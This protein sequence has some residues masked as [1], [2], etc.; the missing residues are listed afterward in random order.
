MSSTITRLRS[1]DQIQIRTGAVQGIG[2]QGPSGP[3]GG[4]GPEGPAGPQG[5]KGDTGF[6]SESAVL[7]TSG[8]SPQS[9]AASTNTLVNFPTVV[10]DEMSAKQSDTNF[11]P[12]AG[13]YFVTAYVNFSKGTAVTGARIIRILQNGAV[14]WANTL[15]NTATSTLTASELSVAG[16]LVLAANDIITVQVWHNDSVSLS[17]NPARLFI[18]RTG[19]GPQGPEGPQG[20]QGPVGA[21]GAA[22]AQGPAGTVGNNN[23]TFAQIAAGTG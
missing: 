16:G 20:P 12:G 5:A 10:V 15:P 2:P 18:S 1:G 19:P 8:G 6:V 11:R 3:T 23:T 7:A 4:S 21:T 14:V 22:G 17:L 13:R 9:V